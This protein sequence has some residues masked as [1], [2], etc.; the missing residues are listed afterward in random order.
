MNRRRISWICG[1]LFL[2]LSLS[3]SAQPD[4]TRVGSTG[5]MDENPPNAFQV[6]GAGLFHAAGVVGSVVARFN[7]DNVSGLYPFAPWNA[8]EM[9]S[10]DGTPQGQ[11][12]AT[13]FRVPRCG[14]NSIPVC[15][16]QSNDNI[17]GPTCTTCTF[18]AVMDFQANSYYVQVTISRAVPA[19]TPVLFNLRLF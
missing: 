10:A 5:T 4:W 6:N 14:G 15:T 9:T 1:V 19:V 18:G 16:V 12:S 17:A 3:A 13:L 2:V 11:V 8:L 7:V